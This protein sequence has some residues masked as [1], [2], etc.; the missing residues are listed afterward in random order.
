[1]QVSVLGAVEVRRDG[2]PVDLGTPKQRALVAVLALAHGWPVS[3]DAIVD[4][5]W[6]DT[7]PPGVAG[8]L[9]SYVS[10]LRRALEPDRA[11]RT[12]ATVLVTAAPGYALRVPD[13][14][15]DAHRFEQ[16]VAV[17]HRTLQP[18]AGA[19]GTAPLETATLEAE[20]ARLDE[21]L[22]WWRGTPYA[23]LGDSDNAIAERT[24][25]EELRLVAAEDRALAALALGDHA[26]TAAEL[27]ALTGAHPLR[28]RLWELRAVALFRSGRQADALEVLATLRT[29]LD[30]ELGLEPSAAVRDLQT[31]LLRQDETLS[32]VPP[33]GERTAPAPAVL[34][35][36]PPPERAPERHL[37]GAQIAPWPM[38]GRDAELAGLMS[39]LGAA[40]SGRPSYAVLTGEPGIGKS[41]LAG[42]M[43]LQ[44]RRRN[45]VVLHGRCSQDEGAPPL[46]PWRAVLAGI[47]VD[48]VDLVGQAGTDE[49][50]R[51]RAWQLIT[52]A[53]LEAARER[54]VALL[55]DDLHWADPPTLRV[56]RM[57]VESAT[58]ERLLVVGAWRA[59]PPPTGPLADAAE[60]FARAHALRLDLGGLPERAA[61]AIYEAVTGQAMAGGSADLLVQRTDGNPFFLVE[62]SRLAAERGGGVDL[63]GGQLPAAVGDVIDRRLTR[64]PDDTVS[65][66]RFA[67]VIGRRFDLST[68]A[69]AA[70]IDEDD[71]LDVVEPAQAAGLVREHGVDHYLFT[72]AL[73]RDRLREGIGA[74]RTARVHARIAEAF[75]QAPGRESEE[76][77]HWRE[78][79]PS[80]AGRAWRS[81]VAAAAMARRLH[82]HDEAAA[83][84]DG[85]LQSMEDD[86][87]ASATD[88]L[89]VLMDLAEAHRWAGRQ[90]DLVQA[91]ER[92]VAAAREIGDAE[93]LARAAVT[94]STGV[95]WRSAP[96]G[97]TNDVVLGALHDSLAQLPSGDSEL[98]CRV[99][100]ALAIEADHDEEAT[101]WSGDALAMARRLD[102][103]A[104]VMA[105]HQ[106]AHMEWL[107]STAPDRLDHIT[108]ALG[109]ARELGD[110]RAGVVCGTL[111]AGALGELGRVE[112]MWAQVAETLAD[113]RRLRIAYGDLVL[114]G[115]EI[116]WAALA[117][118]WD[119]CE[120]G[121]AHVAELAEDLDHG[122]VEETI[123]ICRF[124]IAYWSGRPADALAPLGLFLEMGAPFGTAVAVCRWRAGD[125]EG[126]RQA[127]AEHGP[128][129]EEEANLSA[130]VWAHAAELAAYL[131]DADLAA[132]AHAQLLPLSGRPCAV[133]VAIVMAPV[134]A[135]LAL[136]ASAMGRTEEATSYA[137]AAL[138]SSEA[139]GTGVVTAWLGELRERYGF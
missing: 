87:I 13:D 10:G 123:E 122:S 134:D 41:R 115:L 56:L 20:R 33:A 111:R 4:A 128:P 110:E 119:D 73:V 129:P 31:A 121:L 82:D 58:D 117:G 109:I 81:A 19:W 38:V 78:A 98:R 27:E 132:S 79:G 30:E 69:A 34:P 35:A 92:A 15:V 113:A 112:D 55:M 43:L 84:L 44:A 93:A 48:L 29:V 5:L 136:A 94:V 52:S 22:G 133:G 120:R 61:G 103:P 66:L 104:L 42:E 135:Y 11:P 26:T 36:D 21:A 6:G 90:G 105:A 100:L 71:A 51:F 99:M 88:R 131:G 14:Q 1:M 37:A 32:W 67:A 7:A 89:A 49:G 74:S 137:D 83:L 95:L 125:E 59:H 118:R 70:R 130:L 138:A 17:A 3:V 91:A 40:E 124:A 72:H 2:Q 65:A 107:P 57:L 63:A 108:E 97:R 8:T 39:A 77:R 106:V 62:L 101:R 50:G 139:W 54:P 114:T 18:L 60:S 68:L 16:A 85:A 64:L 116:P 86:A 23:D 9:Q 75:A 102:A 80:Y 24:R 126:A 45:V 53:V 28:E 46:W 47:G 12:P 127:Y 96:P 25:L 76:A